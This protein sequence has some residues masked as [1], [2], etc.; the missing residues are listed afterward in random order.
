MEVKRI[1]VNKA[2]YAEMEEG[3]GRLVGVRRG[4]NRLLTL[5]TSRPSVRTVVNGKK[6]GPRRQT[7]SSLIIY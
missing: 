3:K 7:V 6:K 1:V 5:L 2:S 4:M